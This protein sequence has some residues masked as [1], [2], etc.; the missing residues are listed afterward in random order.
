MC[1]TGKFIGVAF[2]ISMNLGYGLLVVVCLFDYLCLFWGRLFVFFRFVLFFKHLNLLLTPPRWHSGKASALRVEDPGY[3][4]RLCRDFFR[5]K[6]Y[7]WLK[8]WRYRVSTGTGRPGVS[9][10]WL[11]EVQS[12][13]FNF[14]LSVTA[15]KIVWVD[16][17]L[18]YTSMLLRR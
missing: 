16:P 7:Q 8:N 5:V 18:R 3:E 2:H 1:V 6:S 14:Y 9:I 11:G 15:R 12:L 13:I 17:S 10:L 4:S